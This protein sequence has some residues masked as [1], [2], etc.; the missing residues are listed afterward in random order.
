MSLYVFLRHLLISSL[1]NML[2]TRLTC[3]SYPKTE[4]AKM[5]TYPPPFSYH[6]SFDIFFLGE[7]YFSPVPVLCPCLMCSHANVASFTRMQACDFCIAGS[8][9][10][11]FTSYV[12]YAYIA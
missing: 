7:V 5:T 3:L 2:L 1:V 12:S 8:I 4:R 9:S 6:S 10:A 11:C